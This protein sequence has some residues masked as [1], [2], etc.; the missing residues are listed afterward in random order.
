MAIQEAM[1][2]GGHTGPG[3]V[4][5]DLGTSFQSLRSLRGPFEH[6]R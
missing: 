5:L 6:K 3:K 1:S 4:K 2:Q